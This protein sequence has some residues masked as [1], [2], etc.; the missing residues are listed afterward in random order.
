M[1]EL[2]KVAVGMCMMMGASATV[3]SQGKFVRVEVA[4]QKWLQDVAGPSE[5]S[6]GRFWW[7]SDVVCIAFIAACRA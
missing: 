2:W 1:S 3:Q 4:R 5:Q 6:P 7:R